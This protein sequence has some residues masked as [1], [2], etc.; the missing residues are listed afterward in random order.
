MVL[1]YQ[2]HGSNSIEIITISAVGD[3]MLG[4]E[5]ETRI[6]L[7]GAKYP[8]EHIA[9]FL[10]DSDI[11]FANLESPLTNENNKAIWDYTKILD[12]P[13]LSGNK[14][15]GSA[16]YCKSIPEAV[17]GLT[18]AGIDVVSIANN[19]I[20]DYGE[21]GLF[22]T[23]NILSQND[24]KFVGAGKDKN[25]ARTPIIINAKNIK[26]GFLAYCDVYLASKKRPGANSTNY[27]TQDI[28]IL[29][30]QVDVV[31]V[32]IHQGMDI[33]DFPLPN[34]INT[35]HS[36]IDCGA[37][38]VLRHH[39]HVIQG[40]EHYKNGVIVYS[41]GNFIFDYTIDPLWK[42]LIKAKESMIFRCKLSK[43]GIIETDFTPIIIND[44]FQPEIY[45]SLNGNQITERIKNL[46]SE[47]SK[48][49]ISDIQIAMLDNYVNTQIALIYPIMIS[50][51]KRRDF[52]NIPL[53]LSRIKLCHIQLLGKYIINILSKYIKKIIG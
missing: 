51:I 15:I 44:N 5:V 46:S 41:L 34:E 52:K 8:F 35:M 21:N 32:S 18:Y 42:D 24:I 14:T 45:S 13:I 27:I 36:I 47:L 3:I 10:K 19:H 9:S 50:S 2:G 43:E 48:N 23:I 53:I 26:V 40:I 20:M 6:K 7:Y 38:L 17:E 29:K 31:V 30:E 11:T 4:G 25:D 16:I 28:K 1:R 12:K 49:K 22:D 37:D 39:P 33:S